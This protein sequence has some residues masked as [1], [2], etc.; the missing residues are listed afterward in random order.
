MRITGR[1]HLKNFCTKHPDCRSWINN[2]VADTEAVKWRHPQDIK[3]RHVS[4]SFL[5]DNVVIFNVRGNEYRLAVRVAYLTST[6]VI[7]WIGK[8]ADYTKKYS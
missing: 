1:E 4:A 3:D 5:P 8:H 2:W 7:L 6:V